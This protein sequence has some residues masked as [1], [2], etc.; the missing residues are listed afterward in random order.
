MKVNDNKFHD[1]NNLQCLGTKSIILNPDHKTHPEQP[2]VHF[3]E[4]PLVGCKTCE[5]RPFRNLATQVDFAET[6]IECVVD[7]RALPV[8]I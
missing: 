4:P 3:S 2:M 5:N 7:Q 6:H 8:K 1:G